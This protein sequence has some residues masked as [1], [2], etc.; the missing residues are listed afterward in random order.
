[1]HTQI[2]QQIRKGSQNSVTKITLNEQLS[3]DYSAAWLD[4]FFFF[5]PC[6]FQTCKQNLLFG[7]GEEK[8][9]Y[10]IVRDKVTCF[11][12]IFLGFVSLFLAN[13]I[14]FKFVTVRLAVKVTFHLNHGRLGW[15]GLQK[16]VWWHLYC[17]NII[18]FPVWWWVFIT[19]AIYI[20][21][22]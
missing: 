22:G 10:S 11:L 7:Q 12:F 14:W 1:M 16:W 5:E 15:A 13:F 17:T 18:V 6:S 3:L 20:L 9:K 4:F 19:S 2:Y 8:W 21:N